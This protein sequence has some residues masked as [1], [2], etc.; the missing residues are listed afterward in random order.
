M[1]NEYYIMTPKTCFL[2]KHDNGMQENSF[3]N[4]KAFIKCDHKIGVGLLDLKIHETEQ[5]LKELKKSKQ[6]AKKVTK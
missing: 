5:F 6:Y 1:K 2:C 3:P 4:Q